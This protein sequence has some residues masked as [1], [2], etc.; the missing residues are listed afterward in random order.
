MRLDPGFQVLMDRDAP[1]ARD[2][3][4]IA[5]PRVD[6]P[7]AATRVHVIRT[8][9]E[10]A[11][12][13][14]TLRSMPISAIALDVDTD[15]ARP[16]VE[17]R[18]GATWHDIRSI[19]TRRV[20]LAV[21]ARPYDRTQADG[22]VIIAAAFDAQVPGVVACFGEILRLRIPFVMHGAKSI[23]FALWSLGLDPDFHDIFDTEIAGAVLDLGMHHERARAKPRGESQSESIR[24]AQSIASQK[25][26]LRSTIGQLRKYGIPY[27]SSDWKGDPQ[28]RS[29]R[30]PQS[31]VTE[32]T[33]IL[34]L[35]A[36]QARDLLCNG[37]S[38]HVH[39]IEFPFAIANARIE[40]NGAHLSDERLAVLRDACVRARDHNAAILRDHG[41]DPP[42]SQ[43]QFFSVVRG[44]GLIEHLTL[45][46]APSTKDSVLEGVQ[47]LH[48]VIRA[49][50]DH[51]RFARIA[52]E[53]WVAGALT[54][55]DGRLH[56]SHTQLGAATGRNICSA[57]NLVGIGRILRPVVTATRGRAILELDYGQIEVGVAAA[58]HNDPDLIDAYNSGDVYTAMARRFYERD[59]TAAER[60]MSPKAFRSARP[61]LRDRMK[62]FVLAVLYNITPRGIATRFGIP[63]SEA[64]NERD[65]FLDQYP[66]LRRGL[67]ESA[68]YG[69]TRGYA[70]CVSGLKRYV[71]KPGHANTWT[72]N[73]LRNT[74][75]QGSAAIVFKHAVVELD[76][77]FRGTPTQ[78]ILPV[79]DSV[80]IECDRADIE[81]V[82]NEAR[83]IMAHSLRRFYP[84]LRPRVDV[85]MSRPEC[86]NKDGHADSL[87]RFLEDPGLQIGAPRAGDP[88]PKAAFETTAGADSHCVHFDTRPHPR[89]H[90]SAAIDV[91]EW[92]ATLD[93]PASQPKPR[94]QRR[95]VC[96]PASREPRSTP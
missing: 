82:A 39:E 95:T 56:P 24:A 23:L 69:A 43:D 70:S 72:R 89:I 50:R 92:H 74:P 75:I 96:A 14:D 34:R 1:A 29:F 71:E 86:W 5:V 64:E 41:V 49:Y 46:D 88:E 12:F 94:G 66:A 93:R 53:E 44:L 28:N 11:S 7:A 25:D 78:I 62:T 13:L 65:R 26:A 6:L 15:F 42:G 31:L 91:A 60:A 57:P 9:D 35:H 63:V 10:A 16:A 51:A 19:K 83:W 81:A 67:E 85:N 79:H 84:A 68:K 77:A 58:E 52:N 2:R 80:V 8:D 20:M 73:F 87:D 30:A 33:A 3:H 4:S 54:G 61:D 59:L 22:D 40:W 21:W 18:N 55:T 45:G 47:H 90:L 32:A 37:L 27:P 36:H 17:L 76:R 38:R 48:P